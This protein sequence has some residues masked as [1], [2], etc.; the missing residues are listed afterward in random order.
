MEKD[1]TANRPYIV[2]EPLRLL[3][4]GYVDFEFVY[5]VGQYIKLPVNS[6]S[7]RRRASSTSP[8]VVTL[9][10][11]R[12]DIPSRS[13]QDTLS[14][15]LPF[16]LPTRH[17]SEFKFQ[18]NETQKLLSSSCAVRSTTSNRQLARSSAGPPQ[19]WPGLH[20]T[21]HG[22]LGWLQ[23]PEAGALKKQP[24]LSKHIST[25]THT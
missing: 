9:L 23:H 1:T 10:H 8:C 16:P 3:N 11:Q 12:A 7:A 5:L 22:C 17:H 2:P 24:S 6:I 14:C 18:K 13:R 21:V 19:P 4:A 20:H 25:H 15:P